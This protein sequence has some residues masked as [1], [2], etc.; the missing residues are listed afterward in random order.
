MQD[1]PETA[2]PD[3]HTP[4]KTRPRSVP[5][6]CR[7]VTFHRLPRVRR[8]VEMVRRRDPQE[9]DA[10]SSAAA[11]T[12]PWRRPAVDAAPASHLYRPESAA[13]GYKR[14]GQI[15]HHAA[16][17]RQRLGSSSGK[18]QWFT[19]HAAPR[20][21]ICAPARGWRSV[22]SPGVGPSRS[23]STE[24]RPTSRS[25]GPART[26]A[27]V[28]SDYASRASTMWKVHTTS[29][30]ARPMKTAD[31]IAWKV[32]NRLAGWKRR[33]VFHPCWAR[34]ASWTSP[35]PSI[36]G[37]GLRQP[38]A[39]AALRRRHGITCLAV[40]APKPLGLQVPPTGRCGSRW[41]S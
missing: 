41:E 35:P 17:T 38:N 10:E 25:A 36:P 9:A 20:A 33:A 1:D 12:P 24:I 8:A 29:A 28:T 3:T 11:A 5:Q 23:W 6:P 4:S 37:T 7:P 13:A 34:H 14:G 26:L 18:G 31:S 15:R 40:S 16:V 32:Q 19:A 39:R 2:D 22:S 21:T 30:A 27:G